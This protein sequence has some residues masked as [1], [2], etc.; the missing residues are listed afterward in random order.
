MTPRRLPL[1]EGRDT[2]RRE[3]RSRSDGTSLVVQGLRLCAPHVGGPGFD[4]WSGN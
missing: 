4:P 3:V 2:V 1:G